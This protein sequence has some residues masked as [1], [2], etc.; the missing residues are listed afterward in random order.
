V[1]VFSA[2]EESFRLNGLDGK[3][4]MEVMNKQ[5]DVPLALVAIEWI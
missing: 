1:K 2:A 4:F 5:D 3:S